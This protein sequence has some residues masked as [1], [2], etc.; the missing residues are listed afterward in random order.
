MKAKITCLFLLVVSYTF[1]QKNNDNKLKIGT[2]YSISSKILNEKR[3]YIVALPKTYSE[4]STKYPVLVLTDGDYR[5]LY[6][7]GIIEFLSKQNEI[8]ETIIVAI[9]NIDRTRDLTPTSITFNNMDGGDGANF[10]KFI[11]NELL[12][13]VESKFRTNSYNVLA[14]H[15]LGGL[16]A[17]YSY[18]TNSSFSGFI[19]S[20]PSFWWDNQYV[21]NEINSDV[22]QQI[23]NKKIYISSAD[24]Y[25]RNEGM[26]T[27]MRNAQELFYARLKQLGVANSNIKL[28][29]FENENHGT[30]AYM[31][32]YNGIKFVFKDFMLDNIYNKTSDEIT[33]HY[34]R[35]SIKKGKEI[36]PPDQLIQKIAEYKLNLGNDNNG[37]ISLL[38]MNTLNY[39][40]SIN[41]EK[42][43]EAYKALGNDNFAEINY[44]KALELRTSESNSINENISKQNEIDIFL[45][46]IKHTIK[47][48]K[49]KEI[50]SFTVGLPPSYNRA[51]ND[52]PIMLILD[53]N[54]HLHHAMT[55][56]EV[57]SREGQI[58]EMIVVAVNTDKNRTRDLSPT[59]SLVGYNGKDNSQWQETSGGG[60]LF[61]KF[62][63]QEVLPEVKINYR[64]KDYAML[65]GHSLGG[66][67]AAEAYLNNSVFKSYIAMDPSFWWDEHYIVKKIDTVLSKNIKNKKF[68][69]SGANSY[70][71][72]K[73]MIANMRNS[74][75]LFI[76]SLKNA[77][78]SYKN[79]KFDVYKDENHNS[80]PLISLYYGLLFIFQDYVLED[81]TT[82]TMAEIK[83]HYKDLSSSLGVS[84]L[85]PEN[86]INRVAWAKFN[87]NQREEAYTLFQ[88]NINNYPTSNTVYEMLA[89]A[90]SNAGK[91]QEAI[92][93]FKKSL[94]FNS[95]EI[96]IRRIK[97][98]ILDLEK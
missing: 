55:T 47:S 63:E 14:G 88:L 76:S 17:G 49:L 74:Q 98:L 34:S 81:I 84:F 56:I 19:A 6:T 77:G 91:S 57:M 62:L 11:E 52:Y 48:E 33:D 10:L 68:Y 59:K 15:S 53:G 79:V 66:L 41:Y 39:P 89:Y 16:F 42:L 96:E 28:D 4:S 90:Y 65:V 50:R 54:Y 22:V 31:S 20:D 13:E 27:F 43:S 40:S 21:V 78:I 94:E 45:P 70:E 7:S 86:V 80:I 3:S 69:F 23:K 95:N 37:A 9:P 64:T 67:M 38:E 29:Y 51:K 2:E 46:T 72:T 60:K 83:Q 71:K 75:E 26:V 92:K 61:L 97:Q 87:N 1:G 36:L 12:P 24:N 25:E 93:Y 58:P 85:P 32:W 5:F 44:K 82:K 30:S 8:P 18:I 35:L 73:G